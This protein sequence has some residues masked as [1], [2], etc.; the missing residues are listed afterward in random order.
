MVLVERPRNAS[1]SRALNPE[2]EH[3][4]G[5]MRTVRLAREFD[6]VFVHDAVCYMTAESD[7]PMVI[8]TAFLHC[9]PGRRGAFRPD[10]VRENF[11]PCS[12]HGGSDEGLA[13]SGLKW[14]WDPDR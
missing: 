9:R 2:C 11:S 4:E 12:D 7:L 6:A 5:D 8:Q 13:V 10:F 1:V 3:V 14:T